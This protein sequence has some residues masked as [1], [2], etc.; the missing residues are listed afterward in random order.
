MD[1]YNPIKNTVSITDYIYIP[2]KKNGV[3]ID[4]VFRVKKDSDLHIKI[5]KLCNGKLPNW[6]DK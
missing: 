1:Y 3:F 2:L 5:L 6:I 4:T